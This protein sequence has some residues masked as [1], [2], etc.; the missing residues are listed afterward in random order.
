MIGVVALE[1]NSITVLRFTLIC[2]G[3]REA[4]G[5]HLHDLAILRRSA[6]RRQQDEERHR[7]AS[8]GDEVGRTR[9]TS[10]AR[11]SAVDAPNSALRLQMIE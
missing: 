3:E 7:P 4:L 5:R 9:T 2:D 1:L 11:C 10:Q 8:R 6:R